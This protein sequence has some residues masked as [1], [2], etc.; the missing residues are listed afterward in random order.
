VHYDTDNKMIHTSQ[1]G[2]FTQWHTV[3]VQW[4]P[5]VVRYLLD[6]V[7]TNTVTNLGVSNQPMRLGLIT[8]TMP[9]AD[10]TVPV[11]YDIDW[12]KQYTYTGGA[13]T[14]P[15][16]PTNVVAT[17]GDTTATVS[18]TPANDGNSALTG[19]TVTAQPGGATLTVPRTN[20]NNTDPATTATFTGLTPGTAY[21][22]TVTATNV[23]GTSPNAGTT[24]PMIAT[25][26]PP[27]VTAPTA[28]FIAQSTLGTGATNTDLPVQVS[29][30]GTPGS[31]D[32]CD[33]DLYRLTPDGTSTS[34]KLTPATATTTTDRL[35][36]TGAITTYQAQADGCNG[37]SSPPTTG[38]TYTYQMLQDN[39]AADSYAGT[40]AVASC[41]NCSGGSTAQ[42]KVNGSSVT[43][44]VS[45]AYAAALVGQQGPV[46][47]SMA[48]Y[49]DGSYVGTISN[50]A[51]T[52]KYRRLLYT[53]SWP[54]PGDHMIKVVSVTNS[55]TP[56]LTLDGLV[57][58]TG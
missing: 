42:T 30:T 33:E 2:D 58:L 49:V 3:G 41:T 48:I 21:T 10:P 50:T 38:P 51:S 40:W 43:Y 17:P 9:D 16:A 53:V 22:F 1:A 19:Y 4:S 8:H 7:V 26:T 20:N 32:I 15:A 55:S 37:L 57:T 25:G 45:N 12:V 24:T 47:G 35:T 52:A 36:A 54:T 46:Q 23:Y 44:S 5:G 14:A 56:W 28:A 31:S 27:T 18:W 6:G 29:W 11:S 34:L 39:S 13:G